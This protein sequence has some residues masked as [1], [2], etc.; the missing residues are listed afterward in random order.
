MSLAARV[1]CRRTCRCLI[2]A[3]DAL[4][5]RFLSESTFNP[6]GSFDRTIPTFAASGQRKSYLN[7][8]RLA[9]TRCEAISVLSN[10][11]GQLTFQQKRQLRGTQAGANYRAYGVHQGPIVVYMRKID[12]I[13]F[14]L[15]SIWM[16][17]IHIEN[18]NDPKILIFSEVL[19][20]LFHIYCFLQNTFS[21]TDPS[22]KKIYFRCSFTPNDTQAHLK[23]IW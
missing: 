18:H 19:A 10:C 4:P 16:Y 22:N 1:H 2:C 6:S 7:W 9:V 15:N 3:S 13:S 8:V 20:E 21:L 17:S 23:S 14:L 5:H 12:Q 11:T